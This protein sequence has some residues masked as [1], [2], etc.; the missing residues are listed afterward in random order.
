ML[1]TACRVGIVRDGLR[2][3]RRGPN[4]GQGARPKQ[5]SGCG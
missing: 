1:P 4:G 5:K 3:P 2:A